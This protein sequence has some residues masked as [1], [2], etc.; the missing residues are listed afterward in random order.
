MGSLKVGKIRDIKDERSKKIIWRHTFLINMITACLPILLS[1]SQVARRANAWPK[2][3]ITRA[4]GGAYRKSFL[5]SVLEIS[6]R[7][8]GTIYATDPAVSK[9]GI[10]KSMRP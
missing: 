8:G 5:L 7:T 10:S 6:Q 1:P 3:D 9:K 4:F 2:R